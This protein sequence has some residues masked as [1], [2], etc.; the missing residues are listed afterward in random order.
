MAEADI[1][2]LATAGQGI[3]LM[4]LAPEVVPPA[5]IA[6]LAAAGVVVAAGHTAASVEAIA[7]ARAAGL[8]GFTHLFNAMPPLSAR[9]PGPV[10]AALADKTTWAGLIA[11]LNHVSAT[12][13]RV[14]IA[15][16]GTDRTMLVT[17]AMPTVGADLD[18]FMLVGR[19]VARG[20]PP[21]HQ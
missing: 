1:A 15:A 2:L 12:A 3:V 5:M 9:E 18:S 14:A 6:R 16:R 17:D 7:A 19:P 8:S 20:W 13:L 11:D 21:H 4:T 10:G